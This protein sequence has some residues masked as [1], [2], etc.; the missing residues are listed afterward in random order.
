[1]WETQVDDVSA[2]EKVLL[3]ILVGLIMVGWFAIMGVDLLRDHKAIAD[4]SRAV[5]CSAP[6]DAV[7][8]TGD[9]LLTV[10][11]TIDAV[12][13]LGGESP[14]YS[15][16]VTVDSLQWT[17][18]FPADSTMLADAEPGNQAAVTIWRSLPVTV[19]A[20][21][22]VA[23]TSQQPSVPAVRHVEELAA[24]EGVVILL[25]CGFGRP[26]YVKHAKTRRLGPS[27]F[28]IIGLPALGVELI[29]VNFSGVRLGI[30]VRVVAVVSLLVLIGCTCLTVHRRLR[31]RIKSA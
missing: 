1:M 29:G 5:A 26:S 10:D 28:I 22:A 31:V 4:Y 25:L 2:R 6:D 27:Y 11:S 9:C 12:V 23:E 18:D 7:D 21:G 24:G 19:L 14:Q 15:M 16:E 8:G 20:A 13:R 3:L 17:I 30:S